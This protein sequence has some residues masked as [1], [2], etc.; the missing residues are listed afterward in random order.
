M[1]ESYVGGSSI[2]IYLKLRR[3]KLDIPHSATLLA[4]R[5]LMMGIIR[6]KHVV[7]GRKR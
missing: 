6:P 2:S 5:H 4:K 1:K 7:R 3:K